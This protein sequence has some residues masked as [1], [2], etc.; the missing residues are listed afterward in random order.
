MNSDSDYNDY[1][2]ILKV[3]LNIALWS[4]KCYVT[5]LGWEGVYRST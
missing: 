3:E 1:K 5:Q 4:L 2:C